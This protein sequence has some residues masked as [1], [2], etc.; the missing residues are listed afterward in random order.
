MIKNKVK[1][2]IN[3]LTGIMAIMVVLIV[4]YMLYQKVDLTEDNRF[5]LSKQT[6][7]LVESLEDVVEFKIYITGEHLP[8]D[9]TRV[10]NSVKEILEELAE[11]S[12]D[13]IEFEFIDLYGT[14]EKKDE[15]HKELLRLQKR[16]L[17]IMPI[18]FTNIKGEQEVMNIPM[19]AEV[20]YDGRAIPMPIINKE[21]GGK[22]KTYEKAIEALEYEVSNVIRRLLNKNHKKVAILQGHKELGRYDL[23]DLATSLMEYYQVGPVYLKDKTNTVQLNALDGIDVLMI[24]KPKFRFTQKEQYVIDQFIMNGGKTL[25][26]LDGSAGAELDSMQQTGVVYATPVQTLL[27][28]LL[29]KYGAKINTDIVE[30]IQCSKIPMQA[31][32]NGNGGKFELKSWIYSP[33]LTTKKKHIITNNL[34]PIKL[35]FASTLDSVPSEDVSHTVLYQT[36]G[37]NRY[38][39]TPSTIGFRETARGLNLELFKAKPK[40]VAML[41]EGNFSSYFTNR[42]SPSFANDPSS[43]FKNKSAPNR[44]IVISDGDIAK[45]WFSEKNEMIPVGRDK[46]TKYF[47][48]NKKF[49]L[50]CIN[51][52]TGD[53][54]LISVRSK[55]V[56]M[57]LLDRKVIKENRLFIQ[58][59]NVAVPSGIIIL[60]S[61]IFF[62][63]RKIKYTR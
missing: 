24:A 49:V 50:N 22:S 55:H 5:T 33:V 39:K 11:I 31:T 28:P 60:I 21:K 9:I 45:N 56:K 7:Q 61:L 62:F 13:N 53:L 37:K 8:T 27:E 26:M 23:Q 2:I 30:D 59:I 43:K 42:I 4:S 32:A 57:R 3:F 47:F 18:P 41:L 17:T 34:D 12:D 58:V 44:M 20:Y 14:I 46:Y 52:L 51:Y 63:I 40:P 25:W 48:D 15:L 29:Y 35:E 54:E 19:G 38:K 1:D 16:G 6:V 36:S 10:K